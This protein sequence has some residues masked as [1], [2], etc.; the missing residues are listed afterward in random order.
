MKPITLHGAYRTTEID[1][2]FARKP[3]L[4]V[5]AAITAVIGGMA[6]LFP[7]I[8]LA[9]PTTIAYT[10]APTI[11]LGWA[12]PGWV[13]GGQD[14]ILNFDDSVADP[15]VTVQWGQTTY[16]TNFGNGGISN[17]L[18]VT[19]NIDIPLLDFRNATPV[20]TPPI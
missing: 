16:T 18:N 13:V 5:I 14:L 19:K 7:T 9:R 20:V 17:I 8:A 6:V 10:N 12:I 1:K 3:A 15:L 11:D 2:L 4:S